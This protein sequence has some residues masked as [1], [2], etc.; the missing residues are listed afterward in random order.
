MKKNIWKGYNEAKGILDKSYI[1]SRVEE[2][3]GSMLYNRYEGG[4]SDKKDRKM[5]KCLS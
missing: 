1:T 5:M 4:S 2:E 3:F